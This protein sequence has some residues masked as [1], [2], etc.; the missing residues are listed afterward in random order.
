MKLEG[1]KTNRNTQDTGNR[2]NFRRQNNSP[3]TLQRDQRNRDDQKV[4]NPLQNKMVDDEEG[5]YEG[6][7]REIHYLGD[8]STSPHLTQSSYEEYLMNNQL[9]ELSKG[10]K[11]KENQNKYNL[12][13]KQKEGKPSTSNQPKKSENYAKTVTAIS[14]ENEELNNQPV[15]KAPILEIKE[16][17]KSPSSFNFE[18]EI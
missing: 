14:K 16:I 6:E 17:L 13:S 15:I 11:T 10:E 2:G 1:I 7:D 12:R 5:E 3:Q 9:N 18:N 4:Q 8:T